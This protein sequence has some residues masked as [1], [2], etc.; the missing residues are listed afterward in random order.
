[1]LLLIQYY[2]LVYNEVKQDRQMI[3]QLN[4]CN[5]HQFIGYNG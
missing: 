5:N 1:M 2:I 4:V 3:T